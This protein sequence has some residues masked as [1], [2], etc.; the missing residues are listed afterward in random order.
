MALSRWQIKA[1]LGHGG[2]QEIADEANEH[3][4]TVSKVIARERT[5]GRTV[6]RIRALIARKIGKE[7]ADVWGGEDSPQDVA[8]SLEAVG[9]TR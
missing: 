4:T 2:A 9:G 8:E 6:L 5:S 7:Y 3:K 1:A